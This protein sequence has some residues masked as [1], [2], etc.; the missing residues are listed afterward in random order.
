MG[1]RSAAGYGG[2]NSFVVGVGVAAA[3]GGQG[4]AGYGGGSSLGVGVG[5]AAAEGAG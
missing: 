2:G 3:G 5:V 4:A 1:G